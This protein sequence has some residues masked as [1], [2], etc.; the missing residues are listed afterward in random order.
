MHRDLHSGNILLKERYEAYINFDSSISPD[1]K[2]DGHICG[3]LPYLSPE[4]L[5]GEQFTQAADSTRTYYNQQ[6]D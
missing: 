1:E 5:K 2:Q 4:V 3:V 6:N